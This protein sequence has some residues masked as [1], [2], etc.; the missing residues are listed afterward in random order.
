MCL[1]LVLFAA[2]ELLACSCVYYIFDIA[3]LFENIL[4]YL[5]M[6]GAWALF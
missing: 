6:V 2:G 3:C 5:H 1:F 4:A